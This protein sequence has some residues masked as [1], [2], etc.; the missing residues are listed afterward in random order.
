MPKE[1]W[2]WLFMKRHPEFTK[3]KPQVLQMVRAKAATKEV[4]Y[5]WFLEC[6]KTTL[7]KLNLT[8]KARCI[9]FEKEGGARSLQLKKLNIFAFPVN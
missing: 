7:G 1:D 5:H 2:L 4:V 9:S 8:S 6:L 3:Q